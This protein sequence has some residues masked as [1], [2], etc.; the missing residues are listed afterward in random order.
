[1]KNS[2][3]P[4]PDLALQTKAPSHDQIAERAKTIWRA[5]GCLLGQDQENWYA[6]E[7]Q[8]R[9]ELGMR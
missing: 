3:S 4:D 8:L 7:T 6:A 2:T 5:G 9:T 1:M